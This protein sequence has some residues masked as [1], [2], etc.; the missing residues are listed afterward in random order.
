MLEYKISARDTSL[1]TILP[2]NKMILYT[3]DTITR[4]ENHTSQLGDQVSIR[5]MELKKSYILLNTPINN[6]AIKS[7]IESSDSINASKRYTFKKKCF[8]RKISGQKANRVIVNH[9]AYESPIEFLYLKKHPNKYLNN[10]PEIPGLLIRYSVVTVD[11]IL[12][13]ELVR[14]NE[15]TPNRDLFGIPSDYKKVTIDEFM[16]EILNTKAPEIPNSNEN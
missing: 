10:F 2:D 9:P 5:H 8:K 16:D 11:G 3:N 15:Y 14:F 12:D 1:R 13:Y 6:Y 7:D 4:M